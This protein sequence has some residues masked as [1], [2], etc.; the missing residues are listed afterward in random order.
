[1][2]ILQDILSKG[3][4]ILNYVAWEVKRVLVRVEFGKK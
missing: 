3:W 2:K 1:M 4:I